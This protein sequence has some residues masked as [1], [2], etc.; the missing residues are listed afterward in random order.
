GGEFPSPVSAVPVLSSGAGTITYVVDEP[1]LTV[2]NQRPS[3]TE[4]SAGT[5]ETA[6]SVYGVLPASPNGVFKQSFN[7]SRR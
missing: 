5:G 2:L 6:N 7:I 1:I 3:C 4:S